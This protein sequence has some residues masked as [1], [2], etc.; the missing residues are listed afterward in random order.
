MKLTATFSCI[1]YLLLAI[2]AATG[3]FAS[4]VKGADPSL[5]EFRNVGYFGNWDIYAKNFTVS[6]IPLDQYTHLLYSFADID[7]S[8][9]TVSLSDEWADTDKHFA[10]DAWDTEHNVHGNIRQ[11]LLAKKKQPTLK[12]MLSIGGWTYSPS[13]NEILKSASKR[14][15]FA[16]TAVKLMYNLGFD[17]LNLDW[18]HIATAEESTYFVDLLKKIRH[19]M[20]DYAVDTKSAPFLLSVAMDS[21]PKHYTIMDIPAMDK[22]LNF[23]DLMA[24]DYAGSWD[25][26]TGHQAALF[27]DSKNPIST[28][29]NTETAVNYY[30]NEGKI[31][32]SKINL[33][34]AL[35][36]RAFTNT[37]GPGKPFSGV[38]GGSL[39]DA[40]GDGKG[41][42][43]IKDLPHP[44][45]IVTEL[46]EIAASYSYDSDSRTLISYDTPNVVR[47]KAKWLKEKGLGGAMWWQVDGDKTGE[48]SLVGTVVKEL[49][50]LE[51]SKNHINFPSSE[52]ENIKNGMNGEGVESAPLQR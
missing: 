1:T 42:W 43:D 23:W 9:G 45:A 31:H 2:S 25:E 18:E 17:G 16:T 46:P 19:L 24:Y 29:F 21:N 52:Y 22:H 47:Q 50:K 10:G 14:S 3:T 20:N 38:G 7:N 44:G 37:D 8:T 5:T 12:T 32:P 27:P 30:L 33:G 35:Y 26:T 15:Q 49:G 40:S 34:F 11:L 51:K 4:P 13:F 39:V 28:P 48:E 36:G 41:V 6:D